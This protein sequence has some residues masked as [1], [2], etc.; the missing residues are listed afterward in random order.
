MTVLRHVVKAAVRR[1]TLGIT[2]IP[3]FV[4]VGLPV[5]QDRIDVMLHSRLGPLDVTSNTVAVS[6]DP[7]LIGIALPDSSVASPRDDCRA[8]LV[9]SERAGNRRELGRL[10][11]RLERSIDVSRHPLAIFKPITGHD[12]CVGR[13]RRSFYYGWKS[14]MARG[15]I[16]PQPTFADF[17]HLLTFYVCPRPVALVSIMEDDR[18]GNIFP[19]DLI[20]QPTSQL[21]IAALKNTSRAIDLVR[22]SRRMVVSRIPFELRDD[23]YSLATQHRLSHVKWE[24]LPFPLA[25]SETFRFPVP[26]PALR[27]TEIEV[28]E[29]YPMGSHTAILGSVVDEQVMNG[30]DLG[31]HHISGLYG[32]YCKACE[33]SRGR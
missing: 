6:L 4:I 33:R 17:K 5:P 15:R 27:A 31:M 3:Q 12:R 20:S 28:R 11:L 2:K 18:R 29:T 24:T 25:R 19:M 10:N 32:E 14:W 13:M 9:F 7:L 30:N 26:A 23:A 16:G 21:F 1:S 8:R 22:A